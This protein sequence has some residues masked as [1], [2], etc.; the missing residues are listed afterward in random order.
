MNEGKSFL[1]IP[2]P[3]YIKIDVDDGLEHFILKGG[4]SVLWLVKSLLISV[5]DDFHE[6]AEQCYK[7][8][9]LD[10]KEK[11]QSDYISSKTAGYQN[12]HNQIWDRL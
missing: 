12:S 5:N 3:D 1:K 2:Q 7:L 4:G 9:N 8:L 10:M 6:Q 11:R